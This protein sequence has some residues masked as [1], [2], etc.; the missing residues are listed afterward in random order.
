[1]TNNDWIVTLPPPT[2]NGGLHVG[3]LSGPFLAADAFAKQLR[4]RGASCTVTT[5]SDVNQSYVRVTAERQGRDPRELAHQWSVDINDTLRLFRMQIDDFLEPDVHSCGFVRQFFIDLYTKGRLVRKSSPGFFAVDRGVFLD[6]A[7][8]SGY[9][10]RCL[11]PCKC[12]VCESCGFTNSAQTLIA[13][14]DTITGSRKL[15]VRQ[16][17]VLVLETERLRQ[18]L[19]KFYRANPRFRTRYK[20]LAEEALREPLPDFPITLVG[21][22]G[23]PINHGDFPGQVINAWPELVVH[24]LYGHKRNC[25]AGSPPPKVVNFFGFDNSY[26]YAIL[27]AALLLAAEQ[28]DW[29]P[30][31]T[32]TNEFYNLE[33][34]KFSTSKDH[35]IWA[36]DLAERHSTDVIRY[37]A[38]LNAPGWEKSNFREAEMEAV[39][40]SRLQSPWRAV[41][42][43]Y[44]GVLTSKVTREEVRPE[45]RAIVARIIPGILTS[46]SLD[47][48]NLRQAAEDL[49]HLLEYIRTEYCTGEPNRIEFAFLLKAFAQ[50]AFPLMPESSS[51]LFE[52]L[53]SRSIGELDLSAEAIARPIPGDLFFTKRTSPPSTRVEVQARSAVA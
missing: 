40:R 22:W 28:A 38:A 47:R 35:V 1:M 34:N 7:G 18:D 19:L 25:R 21:S 12:G 49:T 39:A 53:T 43:R 15:E 50:A 27:H 41:A 3:H 42:E 17:S 30:H 23:I 20:W 26:F 36:R 37:Y 52:A 29:L 14:R 48:F 24:Q 46:L 2:P 16:E 8:V 10:P 45:I 5:F 9:C 32:V 31:A 4:L 44:A 51:Q 13:P 6:E 33:H 11:D